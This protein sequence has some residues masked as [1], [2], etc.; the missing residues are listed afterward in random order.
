MAHSYDNNINCIVCGKRIL[1]RY[2]NTPRCKMCN[3]KR[4]DDR[5]NN[6][7]ILIH[8]I[9]NKQYICNRKTIPQENKFTFIKKQVTCE[10][11]INVMKNIKY[12]VRL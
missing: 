6:R 4:I 12:K 11:C 7:L 8:Y 10:H 5:H 9:K 2:K 1:N 3:R